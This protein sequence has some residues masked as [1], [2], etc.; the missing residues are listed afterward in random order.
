[1]RA[2]AGGGEDE[3][4]ARRRSIGGERVKIFIVQRTL[5]GLRPEHLAA[6]HRALPES[7]RRLS[8]GGERVRYLRSTF[9]PARAVAFCLFHATSEDLV[10]RV[11][12]VA[13]VPFDRID[14]ALE[15]ESPGRIG[16]GGGR[17][18]TLCP[19]ALDNPGG[20]LSPRG[21]SELREDVLERGSR[22]SFVRSRA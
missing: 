3:T 7:S 1:M 21:E 2:Q 16:P 5:P 8:V 19:F 18:G 4:L 17:G 20:D 14:E 13:Q 12:D 22:P 15:F 6:V 9:A 11:N 10:R